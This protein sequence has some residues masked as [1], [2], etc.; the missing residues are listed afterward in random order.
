MFRKLSNAADAMTIAP[1]MVMISLSAIALGAAFGGYL[2]STYY[3]RC[4][5]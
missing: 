2:P 4:L 3:W 5:S 1:G